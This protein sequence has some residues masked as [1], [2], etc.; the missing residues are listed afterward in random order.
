MSHDETAERFGVVSALARQHLPAPAADDLLATLRPAL[1]LVHATGDQPVV[2]HLGG[3]PSL[4]GGSW[5]WWEGRGPL[6]HVLSFDCAVVARL[7]PELG[8]PAEGR[9]AFFYFDGRYADFSSSMVDSRDPGT[10]PGFRVRHVPGSFDGHRDPSTPPSDLEP[11]PEVSLGAVRTL[12]WPDPEAPVAQAVWRTHGL[13]GPEP[14]LLSA[15]VHAFYE[16]LWK[17]PGGGDTHQ[18]GGHPSPQ[19]G[20]VELEAEELRRGLDARLP[21]ARPFDPAAFDRD[22]PAVLVAASRWQLLLQVASDDA[23]GMMWGDVGQLY[24]LARSPGDPEDALFT[25]QCG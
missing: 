24:Y 17:L 15:P 11:F 16:A 20:T 22:D 5:P 2:G 7:L 25:W 10:A 6:S 13:E 3:Q 21:G 23:A 19:Q 4:T 8:V 1:R 9:L 12:T 18:I 14:Y